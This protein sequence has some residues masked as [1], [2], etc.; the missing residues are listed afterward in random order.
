MHKKNKTLF[1]G[2]TIL[3]SSWLLIAGIMGAWFYIQWKDMK[4]GKLFKRDPRELTKKSSLNNAETI[5]T[6]K[7]T[8]ALS[9]SDI[10]E[11]MTKLIQADNYVCHEA[12]EFKYLG[13]S[14]IGKQF[15]VNCDQYNHNYL[16]FIRPNQDVYIKPD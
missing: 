4:S 13:E 2:L 16:V 11:G 7:E 1:R 10:L 15:R 3:A 5:E 12:N 6:S 9:E 8:S 14:N